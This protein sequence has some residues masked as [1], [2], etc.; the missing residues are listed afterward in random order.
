MA[1]LIVR[2]DPVSQYTVRTLWNGD[3]QVHLHFGD[4]TAPVLVGREA[5]GSRRPVM[6][7]YPAPGAYI[8][9]ARKLDGSLAASVQVFIR[10]GTIPQVTWSAAA[11]NPNI[12][13]FT[14]DDD[15]ATLISQY[16]VDFGDGSQQT[17]LIAP[18]GTIHSHAYKAG[19]YTASVR[20]QQAMRG[21]RYTVTVNDPEY[22]PDFKIG[23]GGNRNTVVAEITRLVT[24]GKDVLIDW[25]DG[26]QSTIPASE[27][28]VGVKRDHV[29]DTADTYIIQCVY[30]DGSTDGSARSVTIPWPLRAT[31]PT[32]VLNWFGDISGHLAI[33]ANWVGAI[34]AYTLHWGDGESQRMAPWQAPVKHTYA[35]P[36]KYQVTAISLLNNLVSVSADIVIRSSA[37]PKAEATHEGDGLVRLAI[38]DPGEP[39]L[40]RVD[41][42]DQ[43]APET[44]GPGILAPTHVY[45]AGISRPTLTVS[46]IPA[47][48]IVK[49]VG[50]DIPQP[51]PVKTPLLAWHESGMPNNGTLRGAGF[52]PG[53]ALQ[54]MP[55]YSTEKDFIDV[56]ADGNG[57]F[58]IAYQY[59]Y[60]PAYYPWRAIHVRR[61]AETDA[62]KVAAAIP[63]LLRVDRPEQKLRLTY[64]WDFDDPWTIRAV[65]AN[66]KEGVYRVDWGDGVVE[67]VSCDA[68]VL[69]AQHTYKSSGPFT[70]T[71]TDP[72]GKTESRPLSPVSLHEPAWGHYDGKPN[73][74]LW[75]EVKDPGT[76]DYPAMQP[77]WGKWRTWQHDSYIFVLDQ[78]RNA[79][80]NSYDYYNIGG[81]QATLTI[82]M[83]LTPIY[84]RTV[85][86]PKRQTRRFAK[87]GD[88]VRPLVGPDMTGEPVRLPGRW[89]VDAK[90]DGGRSGK[91]RVKNTQKAPL[92]GWMGEFW[93]PEGA[94]V[95]DYWPKP[96]VRLWN[97][98]GG[99]WGVAVDETVD[100]GKEGTASLRIAHSGM[101]VA[102]PGRIVAVEWKR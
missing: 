16:H 74:M 10:T 85:T 79:W 93:L 45:A 81:E 32:S 19:T 38:T 78:P 56:T 51:P 25:G 59:T 95:A 68:W 27:A 4:G 77:R 87:V 73:G 96:A 49:V 70:L 15:P 12:I 66:P 34:S 76:M 39:I 80:N 62:R 17:D 22:D 90:F 47:R 48:R 69:D 9:T 33:R 57:R 40:H 58:E 75:L 26:A 82:S 84:E 101:A 54:F 14:F 18:N 7:V 83:P 31:K 64:T 72:S 3:G 2:P 67:N 1:D 44:F 71:V 11:D 92:N 41:W 28:A 50:P 65:V 36:G 99:R 100:V 20:D 30:A 60:T 8:V 88:R 35:K 86:I 94:T 46:D 98:G 102:D 43:S 21:G 91:I 23:Q 61:V 52:A 37:T 5:P 24:S 6:H 42:G 13:E 53:E 63:V 97:L 55:N 29:Y 89:K